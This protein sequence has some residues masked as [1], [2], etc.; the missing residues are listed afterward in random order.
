MLADHLSQISL[1]DLEFVAET[2]TVVDDAS[3]PSYDVTF[4]D[5]DGDGDNDVI[6]ANND[7]DNSRKR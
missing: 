1:G 2:L 7:A 3:D 4:G 6:V 5:L